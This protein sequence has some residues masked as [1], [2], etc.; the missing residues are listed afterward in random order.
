[1]DP[2]PEFKFAFADFAPVV[3]I[4]HRIADPKGLSIDPR[5]IADFEL[6]YI[7]SGEGRYRIL[8][9][10]VRYKQGSLIVTPPHVRHSYRTLGTP[11]EHYALH[12]DVSEGFSDRYRDLRRYSG[13][14]SAI[15]LIYDDSARIPLHIPDFDPR[16]VERFEALSTLHREVSLRAYASAPLMMASAF[17]DLFALVVARSTGESR[18]RSR[19]FAKSAAWLD[20]HFVQPVSMPELAAIEGYSPNYYAAEFARNY[21]VSPVDYLHAK[22]IGLARELLR[23]TDDSIGRI[24]ARCGYEDPYYFSKVFKKLTRLSPRAYRELSTPREG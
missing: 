18:Y 2:V 14:A 17:F 8:D 22:R 21:G 12:F 10:E 19:K 5:V 1:M 4:A 3:H 16:C 20:E 6:V 23:T 13:P 24:A 11:V 9:A 15:S 7:A